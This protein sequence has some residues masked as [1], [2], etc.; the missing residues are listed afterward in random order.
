MGEWLKGGEAKESLM[1]DNEKGWESKKRRKKKREEGGRGEGRS[2]ASAG[3]V[4]A[5]GLN[6]KLLRFEPS[7]ESNTRDEFKPS[8]T[9]YYCI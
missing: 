1:S 6:I 7:L 3:V 8:Q 9:K 5:A 4:P 2:G